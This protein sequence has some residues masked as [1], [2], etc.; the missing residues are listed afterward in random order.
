MG[1]ISGGLGDLGGHLGASWPQ[2]RFW[3]DFGSNMGPNLGPCWGEV[4]ARLASKI[5]IKTASKLSW[6]LDGV[7][8][9]LGPILGG[10][11]GPCWPLNRRQKEYGQSA[12]NLEKPM[13]FDDFWGSRGAAVERKSNKNE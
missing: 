8:R 11:L 5:D 12:K 13:E 2:K 4:E 10:K 1:V 6:I 7:L 3:T 9:C